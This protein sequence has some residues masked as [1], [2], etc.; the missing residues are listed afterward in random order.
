MQHGTQ[1]RRQAVP[2]DLGANAE[3][4]EGNHAHHTMNRL[5]GNSCR[6]RRRVSITEVDADTQ[7]NN[8]GH[9]AQMSQSPGEEGFLGLR[10][11]SA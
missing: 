9:D 8:P 1:Q 2:C 10:A 4:D 6:E 7:Q 5:P 3:Q 11:P